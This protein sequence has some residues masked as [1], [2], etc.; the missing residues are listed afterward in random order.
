M[1]PVGKLVD[2]GG[3]AGRK[4]R[5]GAEATRGGEARRPAFDDGFVRCIENDGVHGVETGGR[6]AQRARGKH[7]AVAEAA[8]ADDRDFDV[9]GESRMLQTVVAHNQI[10]FG[11]RSARF[12]SGST[13]GNGDSSFPCNEKRLVAGFGGR[14]LLVDQSN[15]VFAASEAAGDDARAPT[16]CLKLADK[17]DRHGRL[18]RAADIN[19]ADHDDGDRQTVGHGTLAARTTD[20]EE[21]E[22]ERRK[23]PGHGAAGGPLAVSPGFK[24]GAPCHESTSAWMCEQTDAAAYAGGM[25]E[26]KGVGGGLSDMTLMEER[27]QLRGSGNDKRFSPPGARRKGAF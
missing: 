15:A 1:N 12:K 17:G 6:L 9:A 11:M 2:E 25:V 7:P 13:D 3:S 10:H 23:K 26:E 5:A 21:D 19:V 22:G 24:T 14:S 20:G 4:L 8:R 27:M 18:A 16:A